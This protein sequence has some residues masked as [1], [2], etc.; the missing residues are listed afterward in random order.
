MVEYYWKRISEKKFEKEK[1]VKKHNRKQSPV[2]W[3]CSYKIC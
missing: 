1:W 2:S 3:G